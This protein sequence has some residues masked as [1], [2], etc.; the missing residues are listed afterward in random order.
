VL[1]YHGL[2]HKYIQIELEFLDIVSLGMAYR[3][4]VK[5]KKKFKKNRCEFGST[6]PSQS[7]QGKDDP[8]MHGKGKRKYG[9]SQDNR[10]KTQHKKRNE[11]TKKDTK[12]WCEYHK[13]PWHNTK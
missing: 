8:N 13:I 11:K 12:K 4:V 5:I 7:M 10:S 9:H 1:K 3:Y 6:N 2:L